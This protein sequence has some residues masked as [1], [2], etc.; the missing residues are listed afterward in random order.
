MAVE[1]LRRKGV[2]PVYLLTDHTGF[3]ERHGWEFLCLAHGDGEE[4]QS[5]V[6]IHR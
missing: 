3:Y 4:R 2:S 5:R 6:C 1:D